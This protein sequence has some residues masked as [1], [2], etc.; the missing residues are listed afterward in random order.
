MGTLGI[1]GCGLCSWQVAQQDCQASRHMT[2]VKSPRIE[3]ATWL[4]GERHQ[5]LGLSQGLIIMF[6]FNHNQYVLW[7][8]LGSTVWGRSLHPAVAALSET[9]ATLCRTVWSPRLSV[10]WGRIETRVWQNRYGWSA[11]LPESSS[12]SAI[13]AFIRCGSMDFCKPED[14]SQTLYAVGSDCHC[15]TML[16]IFAQETGQMAETQ[17]I[18][19]PKFTAYGN[20]V[21]KPED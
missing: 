1:G 11:A 3:Q 9:I 15:E 4:R 12:D 7:P 2:W 16:E 19:G 18:S 8:H 10:C 20:Q 21:E 5:D 13:A 14:A 17:R 6:Y